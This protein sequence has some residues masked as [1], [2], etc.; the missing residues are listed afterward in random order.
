[1]AR[2]AAHSRRSEWIERGWPGHDGNV[3]H[4][5]SYDRVLRELHALRDASQAL[6]QRL[7]ALIGEVAGPKTADPR[8]A[9]IANRAIAELRSPTTR[10][11]QRRAGGG[12]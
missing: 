3:P 2:I 6:S 1:M 11:R 9:E 10:P 7:D 5:V 4:S 8:I 12:R